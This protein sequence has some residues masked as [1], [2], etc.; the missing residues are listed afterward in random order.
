MTLHKLFNITVPAS[1]AATKDDAGISAGVINANQSTITFAGAPVV[2]AA[3]W[4]VVGAIFPGVLQ[5]YVLPVV[6]SLVV[7]M[8]IYWQ[9]APV[10]GTTKQKV[11]GFVFA[12]LNSFAIAAT[13]LGIN[14]ATTSLP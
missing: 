7:G 9:S 2:I 11:L 13:V 10:T 1:R 6:L 14:T 4:K 8:L 5:T 3:I 12:T